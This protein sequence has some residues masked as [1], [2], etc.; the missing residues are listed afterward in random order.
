MPTYEYACE[1]CGHRFERFQRMSD[2][3]V[4]RCP[5]CGGSVRR[6]PASGVAAIVKGGGGACSFQDTGRTCC[7]RDDRCGK[8]ACGG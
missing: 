8:P 1:A 4:D 6:L 3:A 7:G 2:P 5:A